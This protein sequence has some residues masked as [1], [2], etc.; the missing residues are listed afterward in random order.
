MDNDRAGLLY[1]LGGF[2]TLSIGDAVIKGMAGL[3][4]PTA[5]AATRY[6]FAGIALSAILAAREG[7]GALWPMPRAGLQWWRGLGVSVSTVAIF[8]ALWLMPLADAIVIT[9]MQPMLTALLAVPLL[10]ER[11][12]KTAL[13]ATLLAFAGVVIVLRPNFAEVGLAALLPLVSALGLSVLMIANRASAG[14]GSALAMQAYIAMTAAVL[15]LL[16]TLVG[17]LSGVERFALHW[18]QWHV[19]A[20]CAFIA[21]TAS[22]AHW[23]IYMGTMRAGAATV[24]PMTYGQLL[25]AVVFGWL[26][27]DEVPDAISM[28]GAA[29]IVLAGLW[30]WYLGRPKAAA[31]VP[32]DAT[33][34]PG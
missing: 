8:T 16:A 19:L 23:L 27:F 31:R 29:I 26:F 17:H 9:F 14:A 10:G 6:V 28:L 4:P 2:I 18:P 13:L 20:R 22:V 7:R 5:M 25:G 12:R 15:L 3:W 21:V 11:L 30:L 34:P 24:A 1:A 33:R 32:T